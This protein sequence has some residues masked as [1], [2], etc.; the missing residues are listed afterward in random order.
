MRS[1]FSVITNMASK[2]VR[3]KTSRKVSSRAKEKQDLQSE[4]NEDLLSSL[5][6]QT[7]NPIK[8]NLKIKNFKWTDKQKEFFKIALDSDTKIVFVKGPAGSAK[9]L[10]SVY[11]GLHLLNG[12]IISDIMYL[13]SAVE[14]SESKLGFL[15]G[16]AEDKLMFYNMPFF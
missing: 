13:R 12:K 1:S 3:A 16:S 2:K 15:P 8:K 6:F 11:C 5:D 9:S 7:S 4:L 14:S 10:V